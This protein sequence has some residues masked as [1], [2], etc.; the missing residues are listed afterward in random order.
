LRFIGSK[1]LLLEE[2][3]KVILSNIKSIEDL[4][5]CDMFSGT[6]SVARYFKK[7]FKILSNDLLC[8]S[9]I[10][11]KAT[12][13]NNNIP[14]FNKLKEI[15]NID[16]IKYFNNIEV[17]INML[18]AK[19]FI[20]ENYSPNEK[21]ERLYLSNKNALKIDYIRQKIE[22]WRGDRYI[23]DREYFY[24]I[25]SLIE[26]IPYVSN[27]AGTYGAYLKHW[28]KRS[29]KDI[30]LL[31]FDIL[32]NKKENSSF[33]QNANSLVFSI[34]GDIL[35]IDPPYNHRQYAPNYHLLETVARYDNPEIYGV[36]GMRPY[37][38][39]K[40]Q[41]CVKKKVLSEFEKLIEVANF[42][43][44]VISYSTEGI[45]S[46][47]DIEGVLKSYGK[48]E[49]YSLTKIPYRRYKHRAGHIEHNLEELIFFI[50]KRVNAR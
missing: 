10:L 40:S 17:T 33:N 34:N 5:F 42:R 18:N 41:Y 27:I 14:K 3:E 43:Y 36:T 11:Q 39:I 47:K 46:E 31:D 16:P 23:D 8:F 32:D 2:I 7:D 44:I 45:M 9:Y 19:P 30:E 37:D 29:F 13:E 4:S 49:T 21:S 50:E 25:A 6:A 22:E 26:A 12:I 38:D 24:L 20:Y 28:D 1:I 15:L 35:Y 48:K